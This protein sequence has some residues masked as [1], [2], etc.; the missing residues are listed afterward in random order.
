MSFE[1]QWT[2]SRPP[3]SPFLTPVKRTIR[4]GRIAIGETSSISATILG[5]LSLLTSPW[6]LWSSIPALLG[7]V[8]G[9]FGLGSARPRTAVFGLL[10]C[11]ITLSVCFMRSIV[12]YDTYKRDQLRQEFYGDEFR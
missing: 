6:T 5:L 11:S 2:Q 9:L 8:L 1:G 7:F 3:D 10:L 12:L 4:S